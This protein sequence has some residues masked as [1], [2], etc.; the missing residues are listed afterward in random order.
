MEFSDG[1]GQ[2]RECPLVYTFLDED[3]E[4]LYQ[5]EN[6]LSNLFGVFSLITI[7]IACLG[8]LGR[9]SFTTEQRFKEI[10]IRKVLGTSVSQVVVL[11]S[12]EIKTLQQK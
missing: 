4:Q 3:F 2:R 10:G 5:V 1:D 12:R 6:K 8:L 9:A 7:F 11:V